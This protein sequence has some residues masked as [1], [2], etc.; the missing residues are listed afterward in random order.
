[1]DKKALRKMI[2][3]TTYIQV[4]K[5]LVKKLGLKPAVLLARLIDVWDAPNMPEW[6]F[7]QQHRLRDDLDFSVRDVE[8]SVAALRSAGVLD[9]K[10]KGIPAMN[11]YRINGEEIQRIL[12]EPTAEPVA[13]VP[14]ADVPVADVPEAVVEHPA[15]E[16]QELVATAVHDTAPE[17]DQAK[18]EVC[19]Q[20]R[21]KPEDVAYVMACSV[22]SLRPRIADF[23]SRRGRKSVFADSLSP[24]GHLTRA[25]LYDRKYNPETVYRSFVDGL[26]PK[27]DRQRT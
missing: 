25:E 12:N 10:R 23:Y 16:E 18:F 24:S 3:K 11:Y 9:V 7:Q 19:M 20:E 22:E 17:W 6:F 8:N 1:M 27:A 21:M 13:D 15:P 14:V 2:S 5:P 26:Q 4:S